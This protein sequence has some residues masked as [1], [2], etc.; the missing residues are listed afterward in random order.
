MRLE[1]PIRFYLL[2]RIYRMYRRIIGDNMH[3]IPT[4]AKLFY[5]FEIDQLSSTKG[6]RSSGT[7]LFD[8][9]YTLTH[10]LYFDLNLTSTFLAK[11]YFDQNCTL[12]CYLYFST[13]KKFRTKGRSTEKV[14][15]M[16]T[17]FKNNSI[18]KRHFWG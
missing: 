17:L 12:T 15:L 18:F 2:R 3:R 16:R 9:F 7:H 13:N 8:L 6:S 11:L 1:I 14:E 10:R 5:R 4:I